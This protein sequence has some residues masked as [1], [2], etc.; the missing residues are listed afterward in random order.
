MHACV[1]LGM[2]RTEYSSLFA[3][4][5]ASSSSEEKQENAAA[6]GHG[7]EWL[8]KVLDAEEEVRRRRNVD[9]AS[10]GPR[11]DCLEYNRSAAAAE[12]TRA[13]Q[14]ND[15]VPP[16]FPVSLFG[17]SFPSDKWMRISRSRLCARLA[18][19]LLAM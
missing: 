6:E 9:F 10:P 3:P 7:R 5:T 16:S 17:S 2:G 11:Q 4:R 19:S 1:S 15:N 12:N 8:E 14:R 13:A 18:S